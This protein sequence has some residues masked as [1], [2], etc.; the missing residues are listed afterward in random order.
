MRSAMPLKSKTPFIAT[1]TLWERF[2][3]DGRTCEL[4][5]RGGTAPTKTINPFRVLDHC[6]T[7]RAML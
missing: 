7:A 6:E 5:Y 4:S 2:Q 1:K 3:R